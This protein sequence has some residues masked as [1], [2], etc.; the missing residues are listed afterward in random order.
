MEG[1]LSEEMEDEDGDSLREVRFLYTTSSP[2]GIPS[3]QSGR[4]GSTLGVKSL[5]KWFS[6]TSLRAV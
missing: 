3:S 2:F 4:P 1:I 6:Q 5:Q